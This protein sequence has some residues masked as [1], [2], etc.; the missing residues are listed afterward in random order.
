MAGSSSVVALPAS[1]V[2]YSSSLSKLS[3]VDAAA[4]AVRAASLVSLWEWM[5]VKN[6]KQTYQ[7]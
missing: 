4:K 7:L 6:T 2:S 1:S 5:R 3:V